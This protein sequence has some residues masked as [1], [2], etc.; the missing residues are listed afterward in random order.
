[1]RWVR[2]WVKITTV[3]WEWWEGRKVVRHVTEL[4]LNF[5][6]Q[7]PEIRHTERGE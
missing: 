3:C 2:V 5:D 4:E 7:T 1:M 6:Y